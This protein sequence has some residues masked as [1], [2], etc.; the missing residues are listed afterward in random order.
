VSRYPYTLPPYNGFSSAE[1]LAT[2]AIQKRAASEGRFVFPTRCSICG[3][4]RPDKPKTVGY[5][6]AHLEDYRRPL[7]CHPCCRNCHAA[8]HARFRDPQRWNRILTLHRRQEAWFTLLSNEPLSQTAPF[9][10]T[11]PNGLPPP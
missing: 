3:L 2:N 9:D 11:Y 6:Y 7:E 5:V 1:R 8:L 10:E 4:S